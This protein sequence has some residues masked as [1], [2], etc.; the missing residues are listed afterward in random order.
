MVP[1]KVAAAPTAVPILV[2][3]LMG[4]VIVTMTM[5]IEAV[6]MILPYLNLPCPLANR[7]LVLTVSLTSM[8]LMT[9]M[10][11]MMLKQIGAIETPTSLPARILIPMKSLSKLTSFETIVNN[12]LH[13][14][15]YDVLQ[16]HQLNRRNVKH[17][18]NQKM[19]KSHSRKT[20]GI[21]LSTLETQTPVPNRTPVWVIMTTIAGLSPEIVIP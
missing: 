14:Q 5:T 3:I 8:I 16:H 12:R 6:A 7:F 13:H 10:M 20:S 9:I 4:A 15:L 17:R 18:R 2:A 11:N 19:Q 1:V 21:E